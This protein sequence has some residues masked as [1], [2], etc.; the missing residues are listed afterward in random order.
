MIFFYDFLARKIIINLNKDSRLIVFTSN[1]GRY[2]IIPFFVHLP[3][4]YF[5]F[6][7]F[8]QLIHIELNPIPAFLSISVIGLMLSYFSIKLIEI[9]PVKIKRLLMGI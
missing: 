6:V 7:F 8:T 1:M 3:Y 9:L 2:S 4:Q 5:L